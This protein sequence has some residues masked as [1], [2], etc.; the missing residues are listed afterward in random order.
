VEVQSLE[1]GSE[2]PIDARATVVGQFEDY[3]Q[4]SQRI[5]PE[6]FMSIQGMDDPEL[7][8]DTS[9]AYLRVRVEERVP[10]ER[11]NVELEEGS[12][13]AAPRGQVRP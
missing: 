6:V 5:A 8:A 11:A 9:C 12:P 13:S 2:R 10:I 1:S 3:V 7:A 4:L